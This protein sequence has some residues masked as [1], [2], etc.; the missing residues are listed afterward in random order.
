MY[1]QYNIFVW[2]FDITLKEK[3][4]HFVLRSTRMALKYLTPPAQ[5]KTFTDLLIKM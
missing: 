1:E 4:K 3:H 2:A 5:E